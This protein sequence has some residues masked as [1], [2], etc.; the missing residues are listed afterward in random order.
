MANYKYTQ[1]PSPAAPNSSLNLLK[2]SKYEKPSGNSSINANLTAA[3]AAAAAA[4]AAQQQQLNLNTVKILKN[5]SLIPK[6]NSLGGFVKDGELS[7]INR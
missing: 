5:E 3:T 6:S 1:Y 4:I 7:L 2:S